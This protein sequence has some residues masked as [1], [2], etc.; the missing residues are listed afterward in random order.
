MAD[1]HNRWAAKEAVVKASPQRKLPLKDISILRCDPNGRVHALIAPERTI[2]VVMDPEVATKRGLFEAQ[3][4]NAGVYGQ[5]ANGRFAQNTKTVFRH[6]LDSRF[7]VRKAKIQYEDQ[8]VAEVSISHD[9]DYAVAVCMAYNEKTDSRDPVKCIIDDGSG[10]PLH[11][12]EW[13]D[14]GYLEGADF[15]RTGSN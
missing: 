9:N 5:V 1:E 2:E 15:T 6:D 12:P 4:P 13:G 10:E 14:S 3:A 11:E 7:F 8:Q